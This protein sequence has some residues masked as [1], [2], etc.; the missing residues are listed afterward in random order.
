MKSKYADG[1]AATLAVIVLEASSV[2]LACFKSCRSPFT[3]HSMLPCVHLCAL[4]SVDVA[5]TASQ[6]ALGAPPGL[7]IMMASQHAMTVFNERK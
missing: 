1:K 6:K 4:Q 2:C 3:A 7:S 5:M